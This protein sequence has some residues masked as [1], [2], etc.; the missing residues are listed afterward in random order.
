MREDSNFS[1][2]S[3]TIT[4]IATLSISIGGLSARCCGRQSRDEVVLQAVL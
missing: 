1:K 3:G 4:P 2:K